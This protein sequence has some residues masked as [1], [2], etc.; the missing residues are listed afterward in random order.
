MYLPNSVPVAATSRCALQ[1]VRIPVL[2]PQRKKA[3][4]GKIIAIIAAICVVVAVGGNDYGQCNVN[5]WTGI[6]AISAGNWHTVVLKENG[7]VVAVGDNPDDRC[8][9][10]DWKNI[11]LPNK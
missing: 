4:R 6:V 1:R 7:T 10:T 11:K 9:V 8:N 5:G 3:K 2:F